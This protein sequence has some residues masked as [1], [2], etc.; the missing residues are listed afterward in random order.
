[1]AQNA[2]TATLAPRGRTAAAARLLRRAAAPAALA[3]LLFVSVGR[4]D[5]IGALDRATA[6]YQRDLVL[7]EASHFLDKWGHRI[8]SIGDDDDAEARRA[9]VD[10]FFSLR[11]PLARARQDLSAALAAGDDG[12]AQA[13]LADARAIEQRRAELQPVV[14]EAI[15]AAVSASLLELEVIDAL[16][17]LRWPPV[18]FTFAQGGLVLVRSP[19]DRVERLT[20]RLLRADV[21]LLSQA[22]LEERVEADDDGMSALV[23]RI[24]GVATYPAHVT[25]NA[26]LHPTLALVVHEWMHHWLIFRPLG[27]AWW[28]GGELTSINETLADI[29]AEEAGDLA[30]FKLTGQRVERPP[31]QPPAAQPAPDP[32]PDV[33]DF[34]RFMRETR[35]R[36][37]ALLAEG[38]VAEAEVWLEE[39]RLG[40][41]ER[42]VPLRKLNTAYFA[43]YG[44]YAGDPRGGGV[45]PID[46]QLRTLRAAAP[47]LAAFVD[48]V[49]RI[50]RP[51]ELEE[52]ARAAGWRPAP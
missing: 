22:V 27:R 35:V 47:S 33:F 13:M 46:G 30:L 39:R 43:F 17:P 51:G 41:Q 10:E 36:L 24:G 52:A 38:R 20:D 6:P 50:D 37:D 44:T 19:R 29:V 40:L 11:E 18:D 28:Q 2:E 16:G 31:W 34:N 8:A 9:A 14:E 7:W 4:G 15:E 26:A 5:A 3:L 21:D 48:Q 12:D 1:M 25:P 42:G 23:V 45:N 32:N 49:A